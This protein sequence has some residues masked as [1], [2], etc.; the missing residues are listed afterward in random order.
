MGVNPGFRVARLFSKLSGKVG[1]S[2]TIVLKIRQ[3]IH[4]QASNHTNSPPIDK[5]RH[6]SDVRQR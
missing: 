3:D 5:S 4:V 2:D 6:V 1:V